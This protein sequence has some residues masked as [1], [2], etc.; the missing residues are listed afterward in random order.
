MSLDFTCEKAT[1]VHVIGLVPTVNKPLPKPMLTQISVAIITRPQW[2]NLNIR[3]ITFLAKSNSPRIST[4]LLGILIDSLTLT[5][6]CSFYAAPE[7][8]GGMQIQIQIICCIN[9]LQP[10]ITS[11]SC[12]NMPRRH[13]RSEGN[14]VQVMACCL[15]APKFQ[16]IT[17]HNTNLF[18]TRTLGT[19]FSEIRMRIH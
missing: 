19:N 4:I 15:M 10:R 7:Q 6:I 18:L 2:V 3:N 9:N 16:T 8:M 17:W 12:L 11:W 14:L 5:I 1:L 13:C